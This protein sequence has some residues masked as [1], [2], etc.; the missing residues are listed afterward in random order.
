MNENKNHKRM[1]LDI[2]NRNYVNCEKIIYQDYK[3]CSHI[4]IC[5]DEPVSNGRIKLILKPNN[6]SGNL[7]LKV[8]QDDC[9]YINDFTTHWLNDDNYFDPFLR[10]NFTVYD[11]E[12]SIDMFREYISK[13]SYFIDEIPELNEFRRIIRHKSKLHNIYYELMMWTVRKFI[14]ST[15]IQ[16]E[17]NIALSLKENRND[18][19]YS[20]NVLGITI[21]NGVITEDFYNA[22][23]PLSYVSVDDLVF[24]TFFSLHPKIDTVENNTFNTINSIFTKEVYDNMMLVDEM[25]M[26]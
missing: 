15:E 3:E 8:E 2:V 1:L 13:I 23:K 7:V 10:E 22:D 9:L 12:S 26:I 24:K 20:N 5:G 18:S 25:K 14:S 17:Y 6:M 11:D 16:I 4:D 19:D 21:E